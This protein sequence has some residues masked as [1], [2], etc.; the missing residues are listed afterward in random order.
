MKA[1]FAKCVIKGKWV[2]SLKNVGM[3]TTVRCAKRVIVI[4]KEYIRNKDSVQFVHNNI[5]ELR[6]LSNED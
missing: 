5:K 6:E 2:Y 1:R 4:F 3:Y